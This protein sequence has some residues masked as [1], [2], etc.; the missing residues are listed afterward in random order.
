M[1]S[2][3]DKTYLLMLTL[4]YIWMLRGVF[5][6]LN[7]YE[8]DSQ[9]IIAGSNILYNQGFTLPPM[10][11]YQYHMQP[12]LIYII[13]VVKHI[14]SFL[15]CNQIYCGLSAV[16]A[17][18]FIPLCVEFVHKITSLSRPLVLFAVFLLLESYAIAMYPNTAIFSTVLALVGFLMI[19]KGAPAWKYLPW[20]CIAP[21]FRIDVIV[22]Y[23]AIFFLFLNGG[24]SFMRS[25]LLSVGAAVAVVVVIWAGYQLFE[26]DP[27]FT[28]RK[29]DKVNGMT[30][31]LPAFIALY[32][33]Y[34]TV[35]LLFIPIGIYVLWRKKL[36]RL[37]MVVIVPIVL[38]HYVFRFNGLA[39]KHYL[40]I[41]PFVAVITTFALSMIGKWCKKRKWLKY[42]L[43]TALVLFFIISVKFDFT[44]KPWRNGQQSFS[45]QGVFVPLFEDQQSERHWRIGIGPSLGFTTA[46]ELMLF[47]G[48]FFY[49]DYIHK[50]KNLYWGNI[51]GI[52]QYFDEK[53][54]D[55]FCVYYMEWGDRM[56]YPSLLLEEGY[57][58]RD[59]TNFSYVLYNERKS[60]KFFN[61]RTSQ[62]EADIL[63]EFQTVKKALQGR[64]YPTYV[65]SLA[66]SYL[67]ILDQM[68]RKGYCEKKRYGVYLIK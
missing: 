29:A 40:Y 5:P 14:L 66:D 48:H 51:Q 21:I 56:M 13:A 28:M 10:L 67:H 54:G 53:A 65:V 61:Y 55:K 33:F 27:F 60:V 11:S 57:R 52:K 15:T 42:T 18:F 49:P 41:L 16:M 62:D 68:C 7:T 47:S 58:M 34:N 22:V 4:F 1:L 31:L 20:L 37:L 6:L 32:S 9:H 26:A 12:I 43:A 38:L 46:D 63:H 30:P 39:A 23:P 19:A 17:F 50:V 44:D 2:R 64:E 59:K 35:N 8:G 45:Q 24:K 3:Q 36:T 25:L